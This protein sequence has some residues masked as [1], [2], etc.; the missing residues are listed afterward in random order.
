MSAELHL[1][2]ASNGDRDE[3]LALL[4]Q[5]LGD[6]GA[7]KDPESW[8]WKHEASPFGPSPMLVAE[9]DGG[10]VGLRAFSRWAWRSN[11]RELR[12]VRA[13]D[14]ATHP[15]WRGHGVF[16]QLTLT[17]ADRLAR[18]NVAFVF[19]TPNAESMRGYLKMGWRHVTRVPLWVRPVRLGRLPRL[20]AAIGRR[21]GSDTNTNAPQTVGSFA[22]VDDLLRDPRLPALLAHDE[23]EP[24]PR[25]RTARTLAY[26][27]WRYA[28]I[29]RLR[30]HALWT[31]D[32]NAQAAVVFRAKLRRGLVEVLVS[33]VLVSPGRGGECLGAA[34]LRTLC[35]RAE[36]DYVTACG[37][38]GTGEA[39]ALRRAGF[40]RLPRLGPNLTFRP[41]A[42]P[43]DVPSPLRWESWRCSVGDL[44]VF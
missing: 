37:A 21:G 14:T 36:G 19:N 25:L 3:I 5:S 33:E 10:L 9:V 27:R 44:E 43:A 17:L 1:R 35:D 13:V 15:S 28:D 40:V 42:L 41:L 6:G 16:S 7:G 4:R 18:E 12:A 31:L 2:P 32:G 20:V 22:A 39:A 30:Y 8:S 38:D 23:M 26:L 29:P 11:G 24:E 34:L